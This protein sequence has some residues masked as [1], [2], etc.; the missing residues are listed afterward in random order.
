MSHS[1]SRRFAR[2]F[3]AAAIL[4]A[5]TTTAALAQ[6][7]STAITYQG[8]LKNA[9]SPANGDIAMVFRLFDAATDG[10]QVGPT[11]T[12][13]GLGG[14]P[15]PVSVTGGLFTVG[16]DFEAAAYDGQERWLEIVVQGTPLTPRQRLAAAPYARYAARSGAPWVP[17]DINVTL[18]DLSG[19]V[20]IGTDSPF[21]KLHLQNGELLLG[22][23]TDNKNWLF[24]YL[25]DSDCFYL[26]E[27]NVGR[28][29]AVAN[30]GNVGIGTTAP[31]AKLQI[32]DGAL[33]LRNNADNKNWEFAYDA[34]NDR[35]YL[36]EFGVGRHVYFANGGKVGIG[37][38]PFSGIPD[39]LRVADPLAAIFAETYQQGGVSLTASTSSNRGGTGVYAEARTY[40]Y[41]EG[42]PA[43]DDA[44]GVH[45]FAHTYAGSTGA[46]DF[47]VNPKAYGVRGDL[48]KEDADWGNLDLHIEWAGVI[49]TIDGSQ[50]YGVYSAGSFAAN[51]LKSFQIDHPLDP[52]NKVLNHYCAEGPEPL[53]VYSGTTVTDATGT[54]WVQLPD[55]FEA[56]NRDPRYQL[57]V[58]GAFAQAIIGQEVKDNAFLIQTSHANVK[59]SWE[60]KAVRNDLFVQRSGAPVE[61]TKS[62]SQRGKYLTPYLYGE[63]REKGIFHTPASTTA[64]AASG[65]SASSR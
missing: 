48:L 18:E 36:D 34:A 57:T 22:N 58:I 24:G 54:A 44:I 62:P 56:I 43:H 28:H 9:G 33:R 21:A 30:G 2:P 20:G 10:N 16:L 41:D 49:G 52:Q 1:R 50:G 60:V 53:N 39:R 8:Q 27:L 3:A 31:Q 38:P 17:S 19:R 55:Y 23:T 59:V 65:R 51:G 45:G 46:P 12:F 11:L 15:P 47:E 63:T 32:D 37:A 29:L 35:L 25:S 5:V 61:I 13:D 4:A 40:F 7:V 6:P 42:D 64:P 26:E 14:N